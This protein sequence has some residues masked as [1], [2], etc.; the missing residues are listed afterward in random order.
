M[1]PAS[2]SARLVAQFIDG[3]I[4][5]APLFLMAVSF[6]SRS[7]EAGGNAALLAL[8]LGAGYYLFADALPG[9]QSL[10]KR[11]FGIA[12]VDQYRQ[13]P[14][15]GFQSFI[16]NIPQPVLGPLDWVFI[17]GSGRQR[18]GDRLAGTI[19]VERGAAWEP[20]GKRSAWD[21]WPVLAGAIL[22]TAVVL[23]ATPDSDA[24]SNLRSQAAGDAA[25]VIRNPRTV[26]SSDGRSQITVPGRWRTMTD[27][28]PT[29]EIRVGSTF[30]EQFVAVHT[31]SRDS[32]ADDVSLERFAEWA[33][34][35]FRSETVMDSSSAPRRLII[36][37]R[38]AIQYVVRDTA[39]AV[40]ITIVE[41]ENYFHR[42]FAWTSLSRAEESEP[43]FQA[44]VQS[45]RETS[46]LTP[47]DSGS[48]RV[49]LG[50]RRR[51]DEPPSG[52]LHQPRS[53]VGAGA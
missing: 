14:C 41:T 37:G 17:L 45:F 46:Q 42:V 21:P 52:D 20:R 6:S 53:Q 27:L 47:A 22:I 4:S 24:V 25:G 38:S 12:V 1:E 35:N 5:F 2:R 34:E 50:P 44:V 15:S 8:L 39:E 49:S 13:T 19:V 36:G 32:I 26:L 18:L 31:N 51:G 10:G 3:L 48:A 43:V 40:W 7:D 16:R 11:M 30:A 23:T 29:L 9:G 33:V 28:D